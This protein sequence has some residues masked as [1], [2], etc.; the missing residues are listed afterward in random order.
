MFGLAIVF[1]GAFDQAQRVDHD[2]CDGEEDQGSA[3]FS[4]NGSF[5][6]G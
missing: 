5:I 3:E 6:P 1:D 4:M 2:E